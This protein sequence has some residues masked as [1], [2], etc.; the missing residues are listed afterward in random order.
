MK[1]RKYNNIT[2]WL[3]LY[4]YVCIEIKNRVEQWEIFLCCKSEIIFLNYVLR[5][6]KIARIQ[7]SG[8]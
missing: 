2:W 3:K 5:V 6:I 8:H 1:I 4:R 7:T